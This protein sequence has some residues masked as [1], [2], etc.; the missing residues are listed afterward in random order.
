[1]NLDLMLNC[2]IVQQFSFLGPLRYYLLVALG[3]RA[4]MGA[5]LEGRPPFLDHS[6]VELAATIPDHLKISS[7]EDKIVLRDAFRDFLPEWVVQRGKWPFT[8]PSTLVTSRRSLPMRRLD[9]KYLSRDQLRASGIFNARQIFGIKKLVRCIP[10]DCALRRDLNQLLMVVL[11]VQ[12]IHKQ[13]ADAY[14]AAQLHNIKQKESLA[15]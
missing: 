8:A 11:S 13:F 15:S 7:E 1:M 4:E 2:Y 3:D 5:S 9:R 10:F 14:T 12:I 6:L